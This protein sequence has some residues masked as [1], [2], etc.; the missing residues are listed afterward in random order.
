MLSKKRVVH[1][2]GE[3][4]EFIP[5]G[6]AQHRTSS[7]GGRK[8]GQVRA[9]DIIT[10]C[11]VFKDQC[12][13]PFRRHIEYD[14]RH[15]PRTSNA[16]WNQRSADTDEFDQETNNAVYNSVDIIYS[17][18]HPPCGFYVVALVSLQDCATSDIIWSR[19]REKS[20]KHHEA[21]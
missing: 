4:W 1:P 9:I 16:N 12:K 14:H 5:R 15:G 2:L 6:G 20:L 13:K 21:Q 11:V 3:E 18:C 19:Q 7:K 17:C 8:L 10:T